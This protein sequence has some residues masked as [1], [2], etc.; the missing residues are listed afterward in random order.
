[1]GNAYEVWLLNNETARATANVGRLVTVVTAESSL[2]RVS[3]HDS[4]P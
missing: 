3:R 2:S 1:M 4:V